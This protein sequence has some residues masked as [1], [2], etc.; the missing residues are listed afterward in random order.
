MVQW[1]HDGINKEN[2]ANKNRFVKSNTMKTENKNS[3]GQ[4]ENKL[5]TKEI[6]NIQLIRIQESNNKENLGEDI[7]QKW[8]PSPPKNFQNWIPH[9]MRSA[10]WIEKY[11]LQGS[12]TF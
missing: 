11:Q 3:P 4:L 8:Y 7:I 9:W 1:E 12:S 10:K 6:S 2:S 5:S